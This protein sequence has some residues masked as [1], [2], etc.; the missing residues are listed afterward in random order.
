MICKVQNRERIREDRI[1]TLEQTAIRCVIR[2]LQEYRKWSGE[3]IQIRYLDIDI[4][5]DLSIY[6]SAYSVGR[7]IAQ[8]APESLEMFGFAL[9]YSISDDQFYPV[10]DMAD[11]VRRIAINLHKQNAYWRSVTLEQSQKFCKADACAYL[12]HKMCTSNLQDEV[13]VALLKVLELQEGDR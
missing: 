9:R 6:V 10:E 11:W 4:H 2:V 1:Y 5:E 7:I 3:D 13:C 8:L 12:L